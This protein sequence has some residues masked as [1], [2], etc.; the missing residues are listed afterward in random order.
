MTGLLKSML[1]RLIIVLVI[2]VVAAT[3]LAARPVEAG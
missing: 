1:L 2:P 3:L